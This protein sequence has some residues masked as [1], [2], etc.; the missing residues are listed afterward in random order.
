LEGSP[1]EAAVEDRASGQASSR[2]YR[3][4]QDCQRSATPDDSGSYHVVPG[5]SGT[6]PQERD[7]SSQ[8]PCG[9]LRLPR[10]DRPH[11]AR[12]PR[13]PQL[14]AR[15]E[16]RGDLTRT[17][18]GMSSDHATDPGAVITDGMPLPASTRT[19]I[20]WPG[21]PGSAGTT[22]VAIRRSLSRVATSGS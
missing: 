2:S 4:N 13:I 14:P 17:P 9:R 6:T 5:P 20:T 3:R 7:E 19:R 8:L 21:P 11:A 16:G 15:G 22:S 12:G 18:P 10:R 1:R